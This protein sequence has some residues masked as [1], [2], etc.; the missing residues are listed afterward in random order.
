MGVESRSDNRGPLP[1][2]DF[3]SLFEAAPGL[4]LV[5]T[6]D[7]FIVA[8]SDGYLRATKTRRERIVG[9][10]LFDIF[11]DN[12]NDPD[13][14]GVRNL[15]ASLERVL[16][17]RR[18]DSMAMQKYDIRRPPEEGGG[19]EERFWSPYNSP[20][21]NEHGDISYIIHRV[22]DVTDFVQLNR[23][24][25][26]SERV[27]TQ[28]QEAALP[29][30]LPVTAGFAFDAFYRSGPADAVVGGDWY[31]ALRLTDGRMIVS[32]GDV[33]GSGLAAAV[34][35]ATI[36][37]VIRGVAYVHPDP[38]MILNAAGKALRAEH[39]DTY[40]SAF[41]GVIDPVAMTLT[42]ASAGH[43][44]PLLRL[45]DGKVT[46]LTYD[47]ILLGVI[48][49]V[50]RTPKNVTLKPRT[51]LVLY[52]D[53]LI[54]AQR[55]ILSSQKQLHDVVRRCGR[56]EGAE[57]IFNGMIQ[58]GV[59]D[60]V[61]ILVIDVVGSPFALDGEQTSLGVSHWAFEA[62]DAV[63]AH[64]ARLEFADQLALNGA[65]DEDIYAAEIVFGELVGNVVRHGPG[66]VS[67]LVDW[68]GPSPV[69]HVLDRGPGFGFAPNL[70]RDPMSE[71][72]RGL[73]IIASLTDD[74]NVT[75]LDGAGSHARAVLSM[76]RH[77]L[78]RP[79]EISVN[80]IVI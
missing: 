63:A 2:P 66:P 47:G 43:P 31:D 22:E 21:F 37:Q 25:E 67:I 70:P 18:S 46:E 3:R 9:R 57:Q 52:T 50:P 61:A 69:L 6:P 62:S 13:A 24:A 51:L 1:E 5:L 28:F 80:S 32:I 17:Q 41:V 29:E 55:D 40:V 64:C 19:F 58:E 44:S 76:S 78:S 36:R 74:F 8:V 27:A 7:L 73:Y 14:S 60:D 68:N 48:A 45:P 75:R 38:V 16:K 23:R 34:I 77:R 33:G 79:G 12:P 39:P 35:M 42:Y 53:G 65:C 56:K 54:E 11:P 72:G 10:E 59:R 20:V 4:Y 49:P 30:A 26:R 71:S 15:R